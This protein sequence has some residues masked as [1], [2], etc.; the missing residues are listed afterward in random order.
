MNVKYTSF[1]FRLVSRVCFGAILLVGAIA[2][3]TLLAQTMVEGAT[4][5]S[6]QAATALPQYIIS[7]KKEAGYY[8]EQTLL[9]SRNVPILKDI[10]WS[11]NIINRELLNDLVP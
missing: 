5:V 3:A 6:E 10:P 4:D 8:S 1:Q 9:G 11:I 7:E 2:P